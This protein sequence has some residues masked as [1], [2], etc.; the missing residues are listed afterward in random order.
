[1]RTLK[2]ALNQRV[3]LTDGSITRELKI[4][5]L[6][7][8]ADRDFF[9]AVDCPEVLNLTRHDRIADVHRAFLKAGAD[10]IRT[11]SLRANPLTLRAYGL[12]EEAFI[13]NF[14]AAEAAVEAVDSTPGSGRRRFVLG[15]LRDDG[16]N[17]PPGEVE[18][19]VAI[20]AEGLIAGG[21]DGVLLDVL[22]GTGR[23]Q[24]MLEGAMKAR[25]ALDSQVSILLQRV[26]GGPR[27]GPQT[28]GSADG[29]VRFRPGDARR[30]AWLDSVLRDG[31]V[32]LIGGGSLPEH[33]AALD[34][35]L[36]DRAEDNFRPVLGWVRDSHPV[37][38]VQPASSWVRFPDAE[39]AI[40]AAAPAL[41]NA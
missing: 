33:T 34:R 3:L 13:I 28:I 35:M 10:I 41:Q 31:A 30:D 20:Q 15:V 9:G 7:L 5:E 6:D 8:D 17:L 40:P 25:A 11:N 4:P 26:E 18:A 39:D 12:E 29:I 36:R 21:A 24:A 38:D 14:K 16:W 32:N 23:I 19:A 37:D 27:F 1:M 22:P 2:D